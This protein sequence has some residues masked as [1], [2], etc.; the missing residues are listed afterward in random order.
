MSQA[1]AGHDTNARLQRRALVITTVLAVV[2]DAMLIPFYPKLFADSFGVTDPRHVGAYLA[3]TCLTVIL[4]LPLWARL[5][6]RMHTLR[7]LVLAQ[8]GAGLLSLV[9]FATRS[10]TVFW[11]ASLAMIVFKASYLLV[12]PYILRLEDKAKH[13][14]TVGLLTVVVHLGGISGA[15]L[16]GALLELFAPRTAFVGMA[17]GDFIQMGAC[18]YLLARAFVAK[19]APAEPAATAE[20]PAVRRARL[21]RLGMI[22]LLFYFAVFVARPFFVPYWKSRS[23]VDS[24]LISGF[25]FAIPA[26]MSLLT[27]LVGRRRSGEANGSMPTVAVLRALMLAALGIVLHLLESQLA[28]LAGRC[29]FGFAIYRAM[30]HLDVLIFATSPRESYAADFS[31]MNLC[32]QLGVLLAFYGAGVAVNEAGLTM[33]FAL[34]LAGLVCT[35]MAYPLLLS[36]G[37][38]ESRDAELVAP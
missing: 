22:M 1:L 4:A 13:G 11:V 23:A 36:A 32:Q 15:A 17:L 37:K 3:A 28:I 35:A 2:S 34:A 24:E 9:C 7:L 31:W 27:L 10:L 19:A 29:V 20:P 12:Y 21:A 8:A 26:F 30:V 5:E 16:G 25:V 18:I 6:R 38:R 33:P 14:D